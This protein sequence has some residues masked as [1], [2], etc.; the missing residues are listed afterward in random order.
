MTQ[1]TGGSCS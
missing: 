1:Q